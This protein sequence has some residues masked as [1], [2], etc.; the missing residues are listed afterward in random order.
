MLR[1]KNHKFVFF[2]FLFLFILPSSVC[3]ENVLSR[4]LA[5]AEIDTSI[6]P[7]KDEVN[8]DEYYREASDVFG[9]EEDILRAIS[10]VESGGKSCAINLDGKS[11]FPKTFPEASKFIGKSA[12]FGVMQVNQY[13]VKRLNLNSKSLFYPRINILVGAFILSEEFKSFGFSW[14]AFGGYHRGRNFESSALKKKR[15][16]EYYY[17][18]KSAYDKIKS[19]RTKE[20]I[21]TISCG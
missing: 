1:L 6:D 12:D 4:Y 10:K 21:K 20:E 7:C 9:I 17:A 15:A 14:K 18:V 2:Y 5:N 19:R 13:W 8:F 11:Y 16:I 3:A